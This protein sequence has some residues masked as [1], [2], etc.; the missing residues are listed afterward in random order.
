MR[1]PL[2]IGVTVA[3]VLW[4]WWSGNLSL[5]IHPRYHLF[6][7][8]MAV[9]ATAAI[10]AAMVFAARS[11]PREE[12]HHEDHDHSRPGRTSAV[13]MVLSTVIASATV[14]ALL[15]LPPATLT[16]QTAG[17]RAINESGIQDDP[18]ILS[19]AQLAS[20]EGFVALTVREWA[21]ILA[22]TSDPAFYRGKPVKVLGFVAE[23]PENPGLFYLTRFVVSCRSVDAQPVG[24]PVSIA[25]WQEL[26][27]PDQWLEITGEFVSNPDTSHNH[28]IVLV[29]S[30]VASVEPPREPYLF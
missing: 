17:N 12:P 8:I 9:I 28:P 21:G 2:F 18:S 25:Q 16:T 20:A 4:L 29:P 19:E 23:D 11:R 15:L 5:Y 3:V 30:D 22:Q 24:V 14:V 10:I 1:G 26:Y 6:S 13:A 27:Q 7:L